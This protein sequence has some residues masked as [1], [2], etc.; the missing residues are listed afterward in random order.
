MGKPPEARLNSADQ[1]GNLLI[2][3]ADQV[4]VDYGS[5][6]RALAH[7]PA[8]GKCVRF[9]VVA[10]DGIVVHHGIHI[11]AGHQKGKP[12]LSEYIDGFR[13][14][15]VRLRNDAHTVAVMLQ[16]PADDGM[17]EGGMVYVGIPNHIYKIALHPTPGFHFLPGHRQKSH[18]CLLSNRQ[19]LPAWECAGKIPCADSVNGSR[20]STACFR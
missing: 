3:L 6:V 13:I 18:S 16:H 2:G 11:A 9:P 15:P 20:K 12:G 8:R 14:L 5:V 4:A 7:D 17:T 1:D 10:G 19:M